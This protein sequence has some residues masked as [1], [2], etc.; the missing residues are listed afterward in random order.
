MLLL[1]VVIVLKLFVTESN[2]FIYF[3]III[4]SNNEQTRI[5]Q[6]HKLLSAVILC[7]IDE[8]VLKLVNKSVPVGLW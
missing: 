1:F 5:T 4:L 6:K 7:D 3:F 8:N 2:L